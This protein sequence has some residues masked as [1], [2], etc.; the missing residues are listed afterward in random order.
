MALSFDHR[1]PETESI[2]LIHALLD[3]GV[4]LF[5]TAD[6][7]TPDERA[8]GHNERLIGKALR[9]WSGQRDSVVV[10]T[11]G[12]YTRRNGQLIPN[13]RPDHLTQAC[14]RSLRTLGVDAIALYQLHTPDPAVPFA[15]SIGA[16]RELRDQGKI[17][18]IGLSNV[19]LTRIETARAIVPIQSVQNELSL[20]RRDSASIGPVARLEFRGVW[21]LRRLRLLLREPFH[22]GV[23]AHCERLGM[24][25]LAYSPLG[26]AH[27]HRLV[28]HPVLER[29]AGDH[30]CSV[31]AV[32]I[33]WLLGQGST[34]IPIPSAR[35]TAHAMDTL[36]AVYLTLTERDVAEIEGVAL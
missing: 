19:D 15:E 12:G 36:D 24:G 26:G 30:G 28:G 17:R 20:L 2:G 14:E 29:I 4:T 32:A 10:A 7:Y 23:L 9:S 16:L 35:S 31:Y 34:V 22:S 3:R 8:P 11:K 27:S 6:V 1:P 25:F 21:W 33:A 13:G 18:W 5:D